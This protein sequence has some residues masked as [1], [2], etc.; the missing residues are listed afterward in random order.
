VTAFQEAE[1]LHDDALGSVEQRFRVEFRYRVHFTRDL[2]S[3]GND[4]LA[5]ALGDPADPRRLLFVVDAG[6]LDGH[7]ALLEDIAAYCASL[8]DTLELAA[9]PLLVPG[10]ELVKNDASVVRRVASAIDAC[11]VDRHSYVIAV[12]GGAVLDAVG[13]AAGISHRGVRLI[14]VPTTVLSQNDSGVGVKNGVNAFGKKN[15]LGTFSPPHAVLCDFSFLPTLSD[16]DWRS[17]ISEAIKVALLRDAAFFAWIEANAGP[18]RERSQ[19]EME[20]LVRRCA[21]LHLEHI[22]TGGDPFELGSSRPLDFGHWAAHKLEQISGHALR[23]G[24]AVAIG[25]ALDT[26]YSHLSGRLGERDW[27]R[28]IDAIDAVGLPLWAPEL[29]TAGEDGRPAYLDGLREFREHLGG[30]L[31]ITLLD[32]VG[33]GADVHEIDEPLVLAA[34][35]L[36]L[37]EQEERRWRATRPHS[38]S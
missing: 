16:R 13:F 11:G 21:E 38:T 36:L 6:L 3:A 30:R 15:F 5:D 26:T 29:L 18:L 32:R 19:P 33:A 25:L 34:A 27:L 8:G 12:G 10:G 2:F 9:A 31:T 20:W 1:R 17:G 4:V 7:P 28:V 24:E 37:S 14:R 22:A 23:H 35:E